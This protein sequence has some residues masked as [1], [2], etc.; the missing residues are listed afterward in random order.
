MYI[1]KLH[2][3]LSG[4]NL[5]ASKRSAKPLRADDSRQPTVSC[6][7]TGSTVLNRFVRD[8]EPNWR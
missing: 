7:D 2:D 1:Q 8:G 6:A 4:M 5:E 3:H